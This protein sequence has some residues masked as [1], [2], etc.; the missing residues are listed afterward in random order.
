MDRGFNEMILSG[1]VW[2]GGGGGDGDGS[3]VVVLPPE[4]GGVNAAVVDGSGMTVLE[5]LVLDEAL[6][7]AILELQGIQA[8]GCGGGGGGKVVSPP[9]AGDGCVEAA[10]AFAAMAT[11]TPAYEDV[12]ADVLQRQQQHHHRHQG[13]MVMAAE[14]DVAP[15]TPAVT[16]SAVPVPPPAFATA[17][18]SIDGGIVDAAVFSGMGN[19]DV[20]APSATVAT[21]VPMTAT[22]SQCEQVRGGSGG[23][24]GRKQRR[25]GRKRKAAADPTAVAA[26]M[27]SQENPLCSLLASNTAGDGGIQIAFST[28]APASK[29][30]K[31]SLSSSSSSISFDGRG[32]GGNGGDDPLYEPDTE[33]L[34]QVKEMIY[35]AAAMRPVTLG[36]EDAGELPR[37]RN[38]R[39]SSDPQTVA[40]RQR[41]ERISERLRVLQKLVPGG[42]K[43]DTA[44]MLDE[45]A[46]YLRFLKSQIRELQTLD[47]RN[48]PNA[49]MNT[50]ATTM[51]T[52]VASGSPI[53]NNNGNAAMPFAFPETL[54]C[55]GGGVEQLI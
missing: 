9:T 20:D 24:C 3:G 51:A 22:T 7:A 55:G 35:R 36:A 31:P 14:Y 50:A 10:V 39:I 43:M 18:A 33:A 54:G 37:R 32:P 41:R 5:R 45:A 34:A 19:D 15:A 1:S 49:T 12:D 25:P 29:R 46:N 48:Y 47:R 11:A 8:P 16:L 38:V 40:A 17:A 30:A 4:V 44:S 53:Y 6:A 52:A 27:P 2:N 13:A 42:A 23:G 26:D 28:S 21:A